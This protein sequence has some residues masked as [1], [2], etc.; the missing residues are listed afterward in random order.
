[1]EDL[2]RA[3]QDRVVAEE[4]ALSRGVVCNISPDTSFADYVDHFFEVK[5]IPKS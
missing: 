4:E 1:M 3:L 5:K 2:A